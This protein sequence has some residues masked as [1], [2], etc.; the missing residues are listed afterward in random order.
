M[1]LKLKQEKEL[2]EILVNNFIKIILIL[3]TITSCSLHKNSK[4]WTK[5]KIVEEKKEIIKKEKNNI[6]QLIKKCYRLSNNLILLRISLY[7]KPINKSF[8]NNFDNNNGRINF[9]G[10][11][12]NISKYKFSKIKNFYQY[13]PEISFY[14]E[15]IIFFDNKGSILRFNKD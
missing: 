8:L 4:F 5:Q 15:D 12:K 6:K 10:N 11:L 3:I 2:V 14:N 9:N 13:D 7:A 1:K